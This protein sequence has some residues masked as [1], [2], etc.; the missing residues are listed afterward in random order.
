M[1][2]KSLIASGALAFGLAV[3]ALSGPIIGTSVASAQ[4]E[5]A[6]PSASLWSQ[7][8]DQLATKLNIQRSA[9]DSAITSAGTSTADAAVAQGTFTQAQA[10]ALK[11]RI[12]AGDTAALF[13]GRGG[14]SQFSS[15]RPAMLD[16]AANTLN[17]TSAELSTQLRSG[18][19]L[20][21]LASAHNTTEQAVLTSAL[22]AAKTELDKLVAA[23]TITQAQA[24]TAYAEVQQQ[25][26]SALSHGGK[27][28]GTKQ[29]AVRQAMLDAAATALN[30][31]STELTTQLRSGQ[32]LA[33]VATAHNTTEQAVL[34]A[35]LAA[36]KTQL[37]QQVS[38]GTITQAQAD[39][40]YAQLQQQGATVFTSRGRGDGTRGSSN[41][42]AT[43]PSATAAAGV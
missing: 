5:T 22:A 30:I 16:A 37:D 20:A 6:A 28:G 39:A 31:S 33:Q 15:V 34:N 13:G 32:T 11:A 24:D 3:G 25:G 42:P 43:V 36:A 17:I 10:D 38:A 26:A 35:A 4:T 12:A 14:G 21:Q 29:A 18:Q 40:T 19:T 2:R 41:A 7:F 27:L 8:L 23:G 9:L 1:Q